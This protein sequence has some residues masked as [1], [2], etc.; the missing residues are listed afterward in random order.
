M[1]IGRSFGYLLPGTAPDVL[2]RERSAIFP[3]S[4]CGPAFLKESLFPDEKTVVI[5]GGGGRAL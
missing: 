1:G 5:F 4:A 3:V 2:K